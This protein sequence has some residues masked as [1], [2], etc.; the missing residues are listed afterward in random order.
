MNQDNLKQNQSVNQ[1]A[2]FCETVFNSREFQNLFTGDYAMDEKIYLGVG[3]ALMRYL[4]ITKD[5]DFNKIARIFADI[6]ESDAFERMNRR[7]MLSDESRI[8]NDFF[9]P[10][11]LNVIK[12]KS[13]NLVDATAD[14]LINSIDNYV[15]T[16]SFNGYHVDRVKTTGLDC[17]QADPFEKEYET[18]GNVLG[19]SKYSANGTYFADPSYITMQ[20]CQMSPERLYVMLYNVNKITRN[21]NESL[22]DFLWRRFKQK[23]DNL[24]LDAK[25]R[26]NLQDKKAE[27]SQAVENLTQ[28]YGNET[29]GIAFISS[30]NFLKL[31]SEDIRKELNLLRNFYQTE[32][33]ESGANLKK[34]LTNIPNAQ[35]RDEMLLEYITNNVRLIDFCRGGVGKRI[36]GKINPD[37]I[38]V[39]QVPQCG[40]L[41]LNQQQKL[42]QFQT[43]NEI[44]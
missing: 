35:T 1:M 28:A 5:F 21:Q 14:Y 15:F 27:I 31:C 33:L 44:N 43:D 23:I 20:F 3:G 29:A 16:N 10:E 38:A 30:K 26:K 42:N 18:L 7:F 39:A 8:F 4:N 11:I 17:S 13:D 9:A 37:M 40:L 41:S 12:A 22:K 24:V 19:K 36:A 2:K 25:M 32:I 34:E 6:K